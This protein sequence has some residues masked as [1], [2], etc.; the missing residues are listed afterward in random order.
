MKQENEKKLIL[1]NN[2]KTK[3][4]K[5]NDEVEFVNVESYK[6]YNKTLESLLE[7]Y[8]E[9]VQ[10]FKNNY[11]KLSNVL[12]NVDPIIFFLSS[13]QNMDAL[14]LIHI[15]LYN[16][17]P[18]DN[19][20]LNIAILMEMH[21]TQQVCNLINNI[22]TDKKKLQE[23]S[24]KFTKQRNSIMKTNN[25]NLSKLATDE[26]LK[27]LEKQQASLKQSINKNKNDLFKQYQDLF[28]Q[29]QD[30]MQK[31]NSAKTIQKKF[32]QHLKIKK[33]EAVK[34]YILDNLTFQNNPNNVVQ[35]NIDN[36]I[37]VRI[38]KQE[39]ESKKQKIGFLESIFC[40]CSRNTILK[41]EHN[42]MIDTFLNRQQQNIDNDGNITLN[43]E[44]INVI[45][46][47]KNEI[48]QN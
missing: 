8:F 7:G 33:E 40:C 36:Q 21:K 13:D 35:P 15:N 28:K 3:S 30:R 42:R 29:Y 5:L 6:K 39:I 44:T 31:N 10:N 48:R 4:F 34:K 22:N 24:E 9:T 25:N 47:I 23:A 14:E 19:K 41:Q 43:T 46:N 18:N 45:N 37:Q 2:K 1:K 26:T 32:R 27:E 38:S 11:D 12:D 16:N 17:L 20:E